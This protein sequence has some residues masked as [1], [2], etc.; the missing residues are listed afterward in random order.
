MKSNTI[1]ILIHSLWFYSFFFRIGAGKFGVE[2]VNASICT[3][4]IYAFAILDPK[5]YTI[6]PS[7]E[8][9]DV[10]NG[11]YLKFTNLKIKYPKLKTLI[12]IGGAL[13]SKSDKYSQLV[14]D[15]RKVKI[16]TESV[17]AFLEKYKFDGI[18]FDWEF[19]RTPAD[20]IGFKNLM[21]TLK[22][23]LREKGYL[24]TTAVSAYRP[25]IDQGKNIFRSI[26]DSLWDEEIQYYDIVVYL[27]Q[28]ITC[29]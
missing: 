2:D 8:P 26:E 25:T 21:N 6:I 22:Q 15:D 20:K 29:L 3:H 28:T 4:Y 18:D 1:S 24:L 7:D 9:N 17:L 11:A 10:I 12:A 13:D 23:Q 27:N 16:F 14:S 19:P 5:L